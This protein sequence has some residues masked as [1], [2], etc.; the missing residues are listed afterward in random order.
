MRFHGWQ[1]RCRRFHGCEAFTRID[2]DVTLALVPAAE[3]EA[4]PVQP[5]QH[6]ASLVRGRRR[7]A[8]RET[9]GFSNGRH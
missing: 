4:P 3:H 1:Q 8:V 9:R 2:A 5:P 7:G 6:R